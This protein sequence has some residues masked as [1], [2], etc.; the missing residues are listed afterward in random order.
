LATSEKCQYKNE[1]YEFRCDEHR[2]DTSSEFCIFHDINYLKD[3]NYKRHK[4][5]AKKFKDKLAEYSSNHRPLKFIGYCLPNTSFAN[6][7]FTEALY[8]NQAT[9]Y[10]VAN[11]DSATFC[12][13]ANF[14]SATFYKLSS[15]SSATFAGKASFNKASFSTIANFGRA[16]FSDASFN[17]ATFSADAYFRLAK[18]SG[19]ASFNS[20]TFSG[21]T[22]FYSAEFSGELVTFRSAKFSRNA[23]FKHAKFFRQAS[24]NLATFSGP[25]FFESASFSGNEVSFFLAKFKTL[26]SF[27]SATFSGNATFNSATFSGYTNF[28]SA[29][30]SGN[31]TFDS[32]E[33]SGE[34][35]FSEAKFS[36]NKANFRQATFVDEAE[37]SDT[38]FCFGADFYRSIFSNG[39]YFS[40]NFKLDTFFNYVRYE[41]QNKIT[42][43][44]KDMSK[45]S[46]INTDITR[47]RFSDKIVWGGKDKFTV[48]EE[49]W[50][51]D[52]ASSKNNI[53]E[54]KKVSLGGALSVY[55]NLRENYEFRLQ[56]EEAG[57]F[58]IR[59]MELKRKYRQETVVSSSSSSDFTIKKNRLITRNIFSLIGWYHILSNYGESL[60]RP[61]VVGILIVF[62]FTF[63]FVTQSN[64][65]LIPSVYNVSSNSSLIHSGTKNATHSFANNTKVAVAAVKPNTN[66]S[67]FIG[68]EEIKNPTQW[69][70]AF[71]RAMGDFI[72]LLT[73]P[74]DIKVGMIDF[75]IKIV[76]GAVTFGLLAIALRRKF[77]RK[78]T[79]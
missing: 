76:G 8:F 10:G 54:R 65:T 22:I 46:F 7:E 69:Q 41:N 66:Y 34:S 62:S 4:E 64:P 67:K 3:D 60:W 32:A 57:K 24:F 51:E 40:A 44:S 26:A 53:E 59:E 16:K 52:S 36:K 20:A 43:E 9:F 18:F 13:E 27:N 17:S 38:M 61:T 74:S 58:F 47:V 75:I 28:D 45:V 55:R 68:L 56:F 25:T 21:Y 2:R 42:F 48:I 35:I 77:E 39:A 78:Y 49:K 30:F 73:L 6:E 11:F 29:E 19:N 23:D 63:F 1:T 50:L 71:E 31:A 70:K 5:V 15:F 79:R 37:F 12:N 33:F 14:D 72:P